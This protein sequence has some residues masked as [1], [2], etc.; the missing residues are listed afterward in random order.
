MTLLS[1][2]LEMK[3]KSERKWGFGFMV[4]AV[5]EDCRILCLYILFLFAF[6]DSSN[7]K[8][9][10]FLICMLENL[11]CLVCFFVL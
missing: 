2:C 3:E 8:D 4:L 5:F 11:I 6:D 10:S 1:G 7:Q 9:N